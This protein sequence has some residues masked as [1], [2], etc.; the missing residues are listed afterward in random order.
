MA[1]ES[2]LCLLGFFVIGLMGTV[3]MADWGLFLIFF[4]RTK[5]KKVKNPFPFA[6][7][8]PFTFHFS[9]L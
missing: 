4:C 9:F 5:N 7:C 6:V 1:R 3:P 2:A 8:A